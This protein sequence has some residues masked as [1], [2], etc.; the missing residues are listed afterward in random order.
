MKFVTM[1]MK[2]A[3][4]AGWMPVLIVGGCI[5]GLG[6][7]A[8]L[9]FMIVYIVMLFQFRKELKAQSQFARETWASASAPS[10]MSP[11]ALAKEV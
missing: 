4:Q 9:G 11:P 8:T 7:L 3:P 2:Q 1:T 6:G 5:T 10:S